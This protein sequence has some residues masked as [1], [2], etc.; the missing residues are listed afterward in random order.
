MGARPDVDPGAADVVIFGAPHG[1]PYK[2]IDNGV[3]AGA[4]DALRRALAVDAGW[5][6]HWDF[7]LGGPFDG[8]G[9]IAV[10]D[11]GNL[12]TVPQ[13]GPGNRR[14]IREATEAVAGR[15]AVPILLGGD[16]SVPIPFFKGLAACGPLTVIQIDAHIDWREERFGEPMGFSSTMRRAS[17]MGH[18][19]RIVQV[20]MRGIGSARAREVEEARAWG[21]RIVMAREV[22][23]AGLASVLEH[24]APGAACAITLD[25]DGLDPSI[26]PA[27]VAPSPGGLSYW[28]VVDLIHAVTAQARLVGFDV[29]E[30]VPERDPNGIAALTAA[31]IVA[32]A[33]GCL[34]RG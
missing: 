17:E 24:V 15:G 28:Q 4:P 30:F 16:D 11:A 10:A 7:D 20:G 29:V 2:G 27:V 23:Q 21:A 19:E 12:A 6:D 8:E 3:Y 22:H 25:C 14:M 31:R 32:N 9:R 26:M 5:T 13:D 1:T 34:A 33:I 18:V